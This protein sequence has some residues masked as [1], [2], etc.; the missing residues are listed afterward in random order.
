MNLPYIDPESDPEFRQLA[1]T[2]DRAR[3]WLFAAARRFVLIAEVV[4]AVAVLATDCIH[5]GNVNKWLHDIVPLVLAAL[6][7]QLWAEFWAWAARKNP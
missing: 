7:L 3:R 6:A 4:L 1:N 2:A 5:T